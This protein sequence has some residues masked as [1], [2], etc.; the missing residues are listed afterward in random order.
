MPVMDDRLLAPRLRDALADP[1]VVLVQGARQ[2]GKTTLA[3]AVGGED[4]RTLSLDR[5]A[6]LAAATSDPD[7][8]VDGLADPVLLDEVQRAP[9]LFPAIKH[10]VDRDRV[11][12]RFLLTGSTNVLALPML[13]ESLAGRM[14]VCTLWPLTQAELER[15]P[16]GF[17]DALFG[18]D[19][20]IL[21]GAPTPDLWQRV[22][23]GGFPEAVART[24]EDRRRAW[25]ESYVDTI[26]QRDVRD[27]ARIE[28]LTE[29]PRLLQLL[30]SRTS[31][32]LNVADLAR[33][34]SSPRSTVKR[35]VALL[36]AVFLV[37][38]IPAW[39]STHAGRVT[40]SPKV[41]LLDT[42]LA[43]AL[44]GVERERLTTDG[45]LRGQLLETFVA[46]ELVKLAS[47]SAVR[48]RPHHFRT[49]SGREVDIVLEAPDG[50]LVG[51]EVKAAASID[52]SAFRGLDAL[53]DAAGDRLHRS[54][55]L[56]GGEDAVP[57]GPG[58]WALPLCAL[59]A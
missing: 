14:E 55:V 5:S 43:A 7:G 36:E 50:R 18:P 58:R 34:L 51:I 39:T 13:S 1:P 56:Y 42:G 23:R 27:L 2:V 4:R 54:V 12:G 20:T 3:E 48:P 46:M 35:Y 49:T 29:M 33:G 21:A 17:V 10:A 57:F 53:A 15:T 41:H 11:H 38:L 32:L 31:G 52:A 24:S 8:F 44:L 28:K 22:L 59:W 47:S 19:D 30:A 25:F 45:A 37:R 9:G 6:V 40:K 16:G 26:L